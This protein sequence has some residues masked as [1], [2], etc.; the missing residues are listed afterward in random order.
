MVRDAWRD[1]GPRASRGELFSENR[2]VF[3]LTSTLARRFQRVC[4][5]PILSPVSPFPLIPINRATPNVT[6]CSPESSISVTS[7]QRANPQPRYPP[8]SP[9]TRAPLPTSP[10][11]AA[12]PRPAS[13][14]TWPLVSVSSRQTGS[15]AHTTR[16]AGPRAVPSVCYTIQP[17]PAMPWPA[18]VSAPASTCGRVLI[19][20]TGAL[21]SSSSE[22]ASPGSRSVRQAVPRERGRPCRCVRAAGRWG[23]LCRRREVMSI[24]LP[25]PPPRRRQSSSTS[26]TY[27]RI[28][29]V[30]YSNRLS[31]ASSSR[32]LSP[33]PTP[34]PTARTTAAAPETATVSP[35]FA[36]QP[37]RRGSCP[38]RAHCWLNDSSSSSGRGSRKARQRWM[39]RKQLRQQS[40]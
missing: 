32:I 35:T 36:T 16:R 7:S 31:T 5:L 3:R 4:H 10:I 40:I 30:A 21:P 23:G 38:Y 20:T 29:P 8:S 33:T 34:A 14:P 37:T 28:G 17:P 2:R 39:E 1:A 27:S 19:Q 12:Q 15:R 26:A 18:P 24:M 22:T 25:T 13:S 11:S 9:A 6:L